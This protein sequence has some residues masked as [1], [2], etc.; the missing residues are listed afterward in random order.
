VTRR[1]E[2]VGEGLW[3]EAFERLRRDK[4]AVLSAAV[5]VG[6]LVV[7]GVVFGAELVGWD[8]GVCRWDEQVGRSYTGPGWEHVLGTDVF[9]RSVLRKVIY[10]TKSSVLVALG[11][12]VLSVL[13]GVGLGAAAGYVGGVV[14]GL[15]VWLYSTM[16]AVPYILLL[17]AL[18]VV[19]RQVRFFGLE[20]GGIGVASLTLGLTGWVGVCRLV[21]M[22][23]MRQKQREYVLAARSYGCGPLRVVVR[24][25]L[26]NVMDLVIVEF[27]L[28]FV[29]FVHAE[30]VLGFLGIGETE[31]PSWGSMIDEARMEI[32][33]GI[34]W[35]VAAAVTA[36]FVV[37]V[38]LNVFAD[39]VRDSID[40][41]LRGG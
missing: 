11:A 31:R 32:V 20:L 5:I 4:A 18:G 28:R 12:S 39:A 8:V 1:W 26:P 16:G 34:W 33:Q 27:S 19:L 35:Q 23:V 38:A 37:S 41:R 7:G 2:G 22:E 14:D 36:V 15:V 17:T 10:A 25:I 30:V 6:Y 24:H 9:G 13:I 3:R 40:P 21:R 29:R